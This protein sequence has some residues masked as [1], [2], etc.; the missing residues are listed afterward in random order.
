MNA[1]ARVATNAVKNWMIASVTTAKNVYAD[2]M[3]VSAKADLQEYRSFK[4][5]RLGHSFLP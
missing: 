4:S 5:G 2:R 3:T 1:A